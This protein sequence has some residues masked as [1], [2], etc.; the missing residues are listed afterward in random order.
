MGIKTANGGRII[1]TVDF[2]RLTVR[3]LPNQSKFEAFD[4]KV[5]RAEKLLMQMVGS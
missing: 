3:D 1:L 4:Y 5:L 2:R